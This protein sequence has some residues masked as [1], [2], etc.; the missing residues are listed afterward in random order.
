M[1]LSAAQRL[2]W[3]RIIGQA[4]GWC[5]SVE[6]SSG[7]EDRLNVILISLDTVRPDHLSCYGDHRQ[8]TPNLDRLAR[9]GVRFTQAFSQAAW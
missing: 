6:A 4:L 8:T 7:A 2:S 5:A 1:S 9:E 3:A